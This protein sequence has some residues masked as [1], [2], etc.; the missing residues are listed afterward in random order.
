MRINWANILFVL[1]LILSIGLFYGSNLKNNDRIISDVIV[2]IEPNTTY[3]ISADSIKN[4]V[5]KHI[6]SSK[7]SIALVKIENEIDNNTYVEKS[8]VFKTV[9]QQ[10]HVTVNQKDP[11]AR[12]IT[13]DSSFYLDKNSN[14]MSLSKLQS[15]KVPVVFGYNS[16]TNLDFLTKVSLFI[17]EDDFLKNNVSQIMVNNNKISLKLRDYRASILIGD[18]NRLKSKITNLKAF[19]IRAKE[20]GDL[21][22]YNM[23]NLQFENQVVGVK[24]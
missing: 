4:L 9:G 2:S 7:D 1:I 15:V 23:I 3:F 19:Y 5:L 8:Q 17:K 20:E 18:N 24:K 10:L 14:F 16:K 13:K 12:L 11:I 21:K 6:N 22:N